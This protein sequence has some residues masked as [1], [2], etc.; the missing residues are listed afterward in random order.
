MKLGI[1]FDVVPIQGSFDALNR[2]MSPLFE[3]R[4]GERTEENLQARIRGVYLSAQS[5]Q[6]G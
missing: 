3:A 5:K 1:R 2:Q 6:L 4:P